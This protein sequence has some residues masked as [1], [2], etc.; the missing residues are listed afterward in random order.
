M[1]KAKDFDKLFGF[2]FHQVIYG[3]KDVKVSATR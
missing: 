1:E 2:F 3:E